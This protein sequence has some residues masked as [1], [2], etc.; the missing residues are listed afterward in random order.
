M[1]TEGMQKL[2]KDGVDIALSSLSTWTK[3]AHAIAVEVADLQ[4]RSVDGLQPMRA[5]GDQ[6]WDMAEFG[7]DGTE[8]GPRWAGQSGQPRPRVKPKVMLRPRG[9]GSLRIASV[10]SGEVQ[11]PEASSAS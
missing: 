1:T 10:A 9:G 8:S 4:I 2:G 5:R 3:N 7:G 6:D 11:A